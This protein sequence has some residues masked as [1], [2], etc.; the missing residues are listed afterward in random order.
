MTSEREEQLISRLMA[1]V[2]T[3]CVACGTYLASL[4]SLRRTE[5]YTTLLFERL[6]R[7]IRVVEELREE[8]D[9]NWNQTFYLLYFRTLG[10]SKNQ[11]TYLELARRVPYQLLLRE[12]RT[13]RAIEAMLLGASGLLNLYPCD[14]Y[15]LG[16]QHE[17]RHFAAKYNLQPLDARAW[18]LQEVRPANHPVL[19]LAQAAE[20]FQCDDF[21]FNRMLDCRTE[22]DVQALFCTDAAPYWRTHYIPASESDERPK[23]LGAFKAHILGIN[24][25]AVLQFTYGSLMGKEY[26]RESALT[27]LETL[28]AEDNRYMRLWRAEGIRPRDAFESQALLQLHTEHCA[29][30]T[31]ATCPLARR[32]RYKIRQEEL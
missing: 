26:L 21:V 4:D 28:P 7:K 10:D 32:M 24:L 1:S 20:F 13:P 3:G 30:R 14:S 22:A 15:T 31:C 17:F 27:L 9:L 12:R 5:I 16:L 25:V 8:A 2:E 11:A 23:R 29:K 18:Q 19:R 6:E